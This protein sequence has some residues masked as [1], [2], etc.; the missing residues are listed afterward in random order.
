MCAARIEVVRRVRECWASFYSPRALFYR[1]NKGDLN[2]TRMAVVVQEMV[3]A[4][5][6]GVMFTVD[7]VS[8]ARHNVVI[9]AVFGLGEGIVSGLI[10]PD[11]YVLNRLDGSLVRQF[12]AMQ[13]TAIVHAAE[14]GTREIDLSEDQGASRVLSDLQ[15][16]S[17]LRMG[18]RLEEFFGTP[19]DIEWCIRNEEI[20]LLQSR[21]IT[22]L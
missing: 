15:L 1:A 5:K 9:E 13:P 17:L 19:Q 12:V 3:L 20:F 14:G 10:T 8:K 2:D 22:S 7:P 16:N 21:P 11:H 4:D 6:S 18:I